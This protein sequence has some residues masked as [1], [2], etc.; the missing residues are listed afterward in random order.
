MKT[1][2]KRQLPFDKYLSVQCILVK[3]FAYWCTYCLFLQRKYLLRYQCLN[4]KSIFVFINILHTISTLIHF[5]TID[6]AVLLY[7]LLGQTACI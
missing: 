5:V 3:T 4:V 2:R 1:H 7:T 6:Y